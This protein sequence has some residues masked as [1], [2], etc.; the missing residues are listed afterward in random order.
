M[1][2]ILKIQQEK[3]KKYSKMFYSLHFKLINFVFVFFWCLLSCGIFLC[4]SDFFLVHVATLILV[5]R[6]KSEK[7]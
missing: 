4:P 7:I 3:H 1:K 6:G 5:V 2:K